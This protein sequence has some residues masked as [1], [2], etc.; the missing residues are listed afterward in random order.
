M[1]SK[2]QL[3]TLLASTL[4]AACGGTGGSESPPPA[5]CEGTGPVE[6]TAGTCIDA[7]DEG[8]FDPGLQ[9]VRLVRESSAVPGEDR[10]LETPIWYPAPRGSGERRADLG[11]VVDAAPERNAGPFPIVLFSHGSCGYPG[12]S[13]F[14][15]PWLATHGFVVVAPPHPGNTLAEYPAC[16]MADAQAR[17]FVERPND[18]I[19]ALDA[20]LALGETSGAL[21]EGVLDPDRIAMTGHSFGGLTTY[22]VAE[23]DFR[24]DAAIPMAAATT[25]TSALSMPS[26]T[27]LGEID[28]TV[29]NQLI[30]EA[31]DRSNAPKLEVTIL[32]TGHFAFS[33]LCFPS[34]DC[35]PP[36][37]LTQDEAHERVRRWVMPFLQATLAGDATFEPFLE[38]ISTDLW[39]TRTE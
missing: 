31:F 9:V 18:M 37:T 36:R 32:H 6:W 21:L 29:S 22:L 28:A 13:R 14:L 24:I 15:L 3:F 20:A 30:R 38:P 4:L 1:H 12:Q 19:F 2:R 8:P 5:V 7:R 27:L 35:D 10:V 26:L 17:S 33:D 16:G 25:T 11:G 39:T 23:Q 34:P